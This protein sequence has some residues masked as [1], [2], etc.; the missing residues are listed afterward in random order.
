MLLL[1]DNLEQ[2][3][4]AAPEL[5][6]LV[7]TC[8]NLRLLATSRERLRVRGEVEFPVAPLADPDAVALFCARAQVEADE[9]VHQLCL[10]LD[11]LPLALELAAARASVLTPS[12]ILDRLSGRLD[13][14]KGGRDADPRQQTLRS[15]IEWS[16]ELLNRDDRRLFAR[17]A[18]FR[19]GWTFEA[20]EEV[21]QADL[22]TL[23]SLVDKSLVRHA[24]DRFLM[25][26]TIREYAAER[27]E[28][29][30][31][32]E[33]MRRRHAEY[34]LAVA[35][36]T[37]PRLRDEELG[38][39]G[40]EWLDRQARELDNSRAALDVLEASDDPQLALRMAGALTALWANPFWASNGLVAE[41]RDRLER[42]LR[43]DPSPTIARAKALD[44]AAEMGHFGGD[45]TAVRAFSEEALE[46]HRRLGNKPGIADSL[47]SV[48]VALGES[49][50][51]SGALPLLEESLEVFTELGNH[52]RVMWGTRT[53][54]WAHA[55][56]GHRVRSR[57]LYEDALG[58]SHRGG[59]KLFEG[60]VLG[61]LSSAAVNEGRLHESPA[62][63]A[64]S[65][66]ILRE[67]DDP[68]E[69]AVGLAHAAEALAPLGLAETA[70]RLVACFGALSEKL[71]GS[72]PWTAQMNELTLKRSRAQLEPE[73]FAA[74]W[75]EG[76][77]LTAGEAMD[78]ALEALDAIS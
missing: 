58:Q 50:D 25:L 15:T 46:L 41:G 77:K 2:V 32:A 57:E 40:R 16:H 12:Q 9:T 44:A 10:A 4:E 17:L 69:L 49:G 19:G 26:E 18:V 6:S 38:G 28:A 67:L 13:L 66:R 72:Y 70:T 21:T 47:S 45:L 37:E 52:V 35:E 7:E 68:V 75:E 48:G 29:S 62:L 36:S 76:G 61:S 23:E 55:S 71:G 20:A 53:L 65:L 30:G 27:L 34:F 54:A 24:D 14:L 60:V 51:W 73:V 1:V 5:A 56:L 8:P 63:A 31:E 42:A 78:V 64:Q 22:D 33:A 43:L 11:N 74:A 59:N 3:V 39:G